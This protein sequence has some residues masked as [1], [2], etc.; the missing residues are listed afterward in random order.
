M[1]V[2]ALI[3]SIK[4]TLQLESVLEPQS[5]KTGTAH[6]K[7][8]YGGIKAAG[9]A[10]GNAA[11]NAEET[12]T[13]NAEFRTDGTGAKWL[14]ETIKKERLFTALE[15]APMLLAI[16]GAGYLSAHWTRLRDGYFDYPEESDKAMPVSYVAPWK[17]EITYPARILQ[18]AD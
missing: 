11:S 2:S 18:E 9:E 13:F 10:A 8:L 15:D 5:A 3:A 14:S 17:I 12:L 1:I 4:E 6:V 16:P 7:L